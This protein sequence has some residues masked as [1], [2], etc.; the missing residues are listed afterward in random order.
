MLTLSEHLFL[1]G[2]EISSP[3]PNN[4]LDAPDDDNWMERLRKSNRI[5]LVKEQEYAT[6]EWEWEPPEPGC[7][8]GRVGINRFIGDTFISGA[9]QSW[10]VTSDGCGMDGNKLFLPVEDNLADDPTPLQEP[11]VRQIR[12]ELERL[13]K[14][15]EYLYLFKETW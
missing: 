1:A 13:R 9:C 12:R 4:V 5:W 3:V 10:M 7:C 15:V 11:E 2:V 6:I 8:A 14:K